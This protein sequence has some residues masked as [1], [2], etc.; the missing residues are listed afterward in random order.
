MGPLY[1]L[2]IYGN[3]NTDEIWK[4]DSRDG[5]EMNT[6]TKADTMKSHDVRTGTE[7]QTPEHTGTETHFIIIRSDINI[8]FIKNNLF[9]NI[10]S[11]SYCLPSSGSDSV[12][13][14]NYRAAVVCLV[15][16]C[17]LLLTAVIVLC[18][19]IHAKS[20]DYTEDRDELLTNTT[21]L[22]EER[23]QILSKYICMTNEMDGLLIKNDNLTKQKDQFSQERNQLQNILNETGDLE[24]QLNNLLLLKTSFIIQCTVGG[25][26]ELIAELL[27]FTDGWLYSNFSFYFISSLKKSWSESRIYCMER[28]ADLIIINNKEKQEFAKKFSHGNE[29]WI[30][31]TDI[32]VEGT[33]KWVDGS[34][35]HL[36]LICTFRFW[37]SGEPT[38]NSGE[39]CVVSFSS[40]WCDYPCNNDFRWICEKKIFMCVYKCVS[41]HV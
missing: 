10:K 35:E 25:N 4:M 38:G 2:F 36:M 11:L 19:H 3:I 32:D 21:N 8:L 39:N 23:D 6:D 9:S 18:V 13:I 17:V 30:G 29:F 27:V 41:A 22:T 26:Y 15:L 37:V 40:R 12:K 24:L 20:T 5:E 16:L 31:L 7:N 34:T 1:R 14:R 28:R 33:W